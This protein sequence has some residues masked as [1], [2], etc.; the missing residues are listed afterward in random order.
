MEP[1]KQ[2]PEK[3]HN[4]YNLIVSIPF[5]V[6]NIYLENPEDNL[7]SRCISEKA[8]DSCLWSFWHKC[9]VS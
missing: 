8:V 7:F 1:T 3:P 4:K 6:E 2:I 5:S 9:I